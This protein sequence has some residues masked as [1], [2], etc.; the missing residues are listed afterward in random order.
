MLA[1]ATSAGNK[2]GELW[3]RHVWPQRLLLIRIVCYGAIAGLIV[4][5]VLSASIAELDASNAQLASDKSAQSEQISSLRAL[6]QDLQSRWLGD[7][8]PL[9]QPSGVPPNVTITW[10]AVTG[11]TQGALIRSLSDADICDRYGPCLPDPAVPGGTAWALESEHEAVPNAPYCYTPR[12]ITYH[13]DFHDVIL[14]QWSPKGGTVTMTLVSRWN[15]LEQVML[16]HELGHVR[17]AEAY[18]AQLNSQSQRLASCVALNTF[19]AN[20]HLWD[21]LN[22]AQNA[23]HAQLRADCRPEV[24]CIP[25]GWM[26]WS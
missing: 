1:V 11:T 16:T 5:A 12:T 21:G 6:V 7:N 13:W 22:A 9:W 26:G 8:P 24:G 10:F 14:P 19:W 20:P 23:Y 18:L 25:P 15:A 3:L 2:A 4:N 17:V